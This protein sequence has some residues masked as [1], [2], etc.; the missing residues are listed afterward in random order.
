MSEP[1]VVIRDPQSLLYRCADGSWSE[2]VFSAEAFG[3]AQ[4]ALRYCGK[5]HLGAFQIVLAAPPNPSIVGVP[6]SDG[7]ILRQ[8]S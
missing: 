7:Q 2:D 4:E 1:K 3:N 5:H 6:F 8:A